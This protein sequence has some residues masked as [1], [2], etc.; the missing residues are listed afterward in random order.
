MSENTDSACLVVSEE[1]GDVS[2]SVD[3]IIKKYEDLTTLKSDLEKLLGYKSN[4]E[5]LIK[6]DNFTL[7][8]MLLHK[9][10]KTEV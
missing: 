1:T 2:V 7:E 4:E 8:K 10:D 6:K 3:G 5:K 9:T